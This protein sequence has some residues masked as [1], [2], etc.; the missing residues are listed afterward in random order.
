MP[1]Q[2]INIG[3]APNDGTGDDAR[4]FCQKIKA[5]FLYLDGLIGAMSAAVTVAGKPFELLK[6]PDNTGGASVIEVN[7]VIYG[8]ATNG[9]ILKAKYTN[10]LADGDKDNIGTA[11]DF[12]DGNYLPLNIQEIA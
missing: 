11:P 8:F 12:A 7:D 1:L 4:T 9:I 10:A 2:D 3:T 6:N 5:N